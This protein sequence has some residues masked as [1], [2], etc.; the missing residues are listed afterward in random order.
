MSSRRVTVTLTK[1][2]ATHLW[3][4]ADMA[5]DLEDTGYTPS[6]YAAGR[7]A[8]NALKRAMH[9]GSATSEPEERPRLDLWHE[10]REQECD[11][12][13]M[14]ALDAGHELESCFWRE[15]CRRHGTLAEA[16]RLAQGIER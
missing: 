5:G 11:G 13:A 10:E 12:Y 7:R 8:M 1:A 14:E 4:L 3:S 15:E 16:Y 6:Q 9:D 2:Q